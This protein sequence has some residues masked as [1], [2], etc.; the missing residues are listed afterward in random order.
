MVSTA[1]VWNPSVSQESTYGPI[2]VNVAMALI[3][4][5]PMTVQDP[6]APLAL[7]A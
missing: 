4:M 6:C 2:W 5:V 7:T 3:G 1:G